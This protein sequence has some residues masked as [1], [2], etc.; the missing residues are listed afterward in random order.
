MTEP[1]KKRLSSRLAYSVERLAAEADC[2]RS[3]IFSEIAA[4]RLVARKLGRR[5]IV[6]RSDAI[7]WLRNLPTVQR[8]ETMSE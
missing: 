3:L 7:R 4:G 2:G 6:R 1:Q 8:G 5:T